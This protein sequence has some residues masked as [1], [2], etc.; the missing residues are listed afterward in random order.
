MF[1]GKREID[2]LKLIYYSNEEIAERLCLALNT[3]K[4]YKTNL[5]EGLGA[6]SD[7]QIVILA[8]KDGLI[9]L[10]DLKTE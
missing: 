6:N 1:I 4:T 7:R 10:E 3:V 8:L 9:K 2:V 5:R